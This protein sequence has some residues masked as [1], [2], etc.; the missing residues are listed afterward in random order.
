[1]LRE[2]LYAALDWRPGGELPPFEFVVAHP[3]VKIFHEGWGRPG[4]TALVAEEE[5]RPVGIVWY[6]LFTTAEHGDFEPDDDLGRM[7]R[8][9]GVIRR[10][11]A[12]QIVGERCARGSAVTRRCRVRLVERTRVA[13]G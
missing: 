5:G 12:V 9:V 8:D 11:I 7:V 10:A 13:G 4:D 3:Q 6:R 1:M 2:M